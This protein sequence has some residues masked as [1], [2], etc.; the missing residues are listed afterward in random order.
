MK[1]FG[2][3]D[4]AAPGWARENV[5]FAGEGE[6]SGLVF[7]ET[8]RGF[9]LRFFAAGRFVV[10][11]HRAG[12]ERV[13]VCAADFR[14]ADVLVRGVAQCTAGGLGLVAGG[15]AG[16]VGVVPTVIGGAVVVASVVGCV[17]VVPSVL[18]GVVGAASC[19]GVV[20]V[21]VVATVS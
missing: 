7:G 11:G 19:A 4:C 16:V 20:D 8:V 3:P 9:A 12:F 10:A 18:A 5:G 17:V 2:T 21:V 14:L 6:P 1:K 13:P 15:A